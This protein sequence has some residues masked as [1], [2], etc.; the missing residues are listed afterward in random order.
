GGRRLPFAGDCL[1]RWSRV[2]RCFVGVLEYEWLLAEP[3]NSLP[4]AVGGAGRAHCAKL[5]LVA[6]DGCK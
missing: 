5:V 2:H 4:C 1:W 6:V 3:S